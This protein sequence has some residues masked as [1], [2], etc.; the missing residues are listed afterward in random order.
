[1]S[2]A[3]TDLFTET[4]LPSA[5]TTYQVATVCRNVERLHSDVPRQVRIPCIWD[6]VRAKREAMQGFSPRESSHWRTQEST[7][8]LYL[9]WLSRLQ[10]A[11]CPN[12]SLEH[13]LFSNFLPWFRSFDYLVLWYLVFLSYK[14]CLMVLVSVL[15]H[16]AP[17]KYIF[18]GKMK[19]KYFCP[20]LCCITI[21]PN[22]ILL[23]TFT[24]CC[25]ALFPS[26]S[27][28]K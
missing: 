12:R 3:S 26:A 5:D 25:N 7:N 14:V 8:V 17:L 6:E 27:F 9:T 16:R 21:I 10:R 1:M 18:G 4:M 20:F 28:W 22:A 11:T 2:W 13:I 15:F 23:L 24:P 19:K